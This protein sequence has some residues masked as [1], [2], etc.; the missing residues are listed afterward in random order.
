MFNTITIP[1]GLEGFIN[2]NTTISQTVTDR[3]IYLID[4]KL[5]EREE[6][7]ICP[8]CGRRM[9][10][11]DTYGISLGHIPIGTTFSA[12]R[13]EK[14]RYICPE[15][16][17]TGMQEVPFQAGSRRITVALHSMAKDL[18]GLG[19]NNKA[20]AGITGLG[21]NTVKEIDKERLLEKYTIDGKQLRRPE[22]QARY[23]G[24]DE[25]LLH[26]G[27]EYATIIIDL[28]TGHV[29]WLAHGKRKKALCDFIDFVG[30]EWMDGVEAIACDMNSD[31]QEVFDDRC[32]HIQ[33]VFDYF[34][35]R[36]NFNDKV[37]AAVRKD[38]QRRLLA[39]GRTEDAKKLKRTKYI[40]SSNRSTLKEKDEASLK[41]RDAELEGRIFSGGKVK[42]VKGG[43]MDL[44][45]SL[46][47]ENGLILM[48][49]VVKEKLSHAYTLDDECRMSSEIT[50]IIDI[51]NDT[52]D[53]HFMWFARLLENHYEG[54]IAH[55][56]Y[57]ISSGKVEGTN[58]LIKTLRRRAYGYCDDD[59]FF[60]KI[61][62]ESRR[63][64]VRNPKSHK[65]YD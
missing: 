40:L 42:E 31:Y 3:S 20:V 55:A 32:P 62:D 8:R 37:V 58:N 2:T 28:E 24:V 38:E 33:V 34:H 27:H 46:L 36:K 47:K 12:V 23:L 1:S 63:E 49:D 7:R 5:Q 6:D 57:R 9:H 21:K 56:T 44:Y 15:C 39:E 25:F 64:Y 18:L 53:K 26:K 60:L 48:T 13:F 35:I 41:D 51:C 45:E 19:F 30:E 50:E 65:I 17:A 11:H 61:M 29:L 14:Y 16:G 59:Y 4:G 43:N 10:I 52:G 22:R 54:I